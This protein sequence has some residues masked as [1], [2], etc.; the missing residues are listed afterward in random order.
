MR[1][2]IRKPGR[3]GGLPA[4]LDHNTRV[5]VVGKDEGEARAAAQEIAHNA[6][7]NVAYY[8]GPV[9]ELMKSRPRQSSR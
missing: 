1:N 9:E 7:Q 4:A 3:S 8:A 6:F 2:H 5:F